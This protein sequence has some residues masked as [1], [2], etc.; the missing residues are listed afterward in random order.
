[1]TECR[2]SQEVEQWLQGDLS[3]AEEIED[4][5]QHI[6]ACSI[7]KN[8]YDRLALAQRHLEAGGQADKLP[9]ISQTEIDLVAR[10]VLPDKRAQNLPWTVYMA[11]AACL[12]L[13][14]SVGLFV[15]SP[16]QP[17][18]KKNQSAVSGLQ[19]R[20][21]DSNEPP[22][23]LWGF[24]FD[25]AQNLVFE[26]DNL[27][28]IDRC[29]EDGFIQLA[30]RSHSQAPYVFVVAILADRSIKPVFSEQQLSFSTRASG[31]P[32]PLDKS[33]AVK[34]WTR[35]QAQTILTVF[36]KQSLSFTR[37]KSLSSATTDKSIKDRLAEIAPEAMLHLWQRS[38][39]A[40]TTQ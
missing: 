25:A 39:K 11:A 10:Q 24:C 9:V 16:S 7:C 38:T 33:I 37:L 12:L 32:E 23:K 18:S 27:D 14:V 26:I 22:P 31:K 30:A 5:R 40:D 2:R 15:L 17:D 4:L 3:D 28:A 29:P 34:D 36:S 6:R 1:M 21:S 19:A 8:H 35:L 20:S 13:I